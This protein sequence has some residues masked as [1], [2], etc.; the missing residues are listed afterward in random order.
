MKIAE[1][2]ITPI[3]ITSL[4]M[5]AI[6]TFGSNTSGRH[7]AGAAKDAVKWGAVFGQGRGLQG[8]CYAIPTKGRFPELP[9]LPLPEIKSY[10]DD[11]WNC[12][13][14]MHPNRIFYIT[15]VGCGLAGYKPEQIAPL[16]WNSPH[17]QTDNFT[18]PE[19]FWNVIQKL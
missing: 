1:N 3:V 8:R 17:R 19:S 6:F 12:V 13:T 18:L 15:P 4:P 7:G 14:H 16:F 2:R 5:N 11:F 10:I 9:V